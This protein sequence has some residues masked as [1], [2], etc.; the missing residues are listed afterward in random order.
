[1]LHNETATHVHATTTKVKKKKHAEY[2][3][4]LDITQRN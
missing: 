4:E 3:V 2:I 1:M